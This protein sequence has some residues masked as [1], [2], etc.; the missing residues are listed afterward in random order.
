MFFLFVF[1]TGKMKLHRTHHY[2][3]QVVTQIECIKASYCDFVVWCPND[4]DIERIEPDQ[5][6]WAEIAEKCTKYFQEAII[7]EMLG[8]SHTIQHAKKAV[9]PY[10]YCQYHTEKKEKMIDCA[11]QS[12]P[13]NDFPNAL[14]RKN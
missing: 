10:D 14:Y 9:A 5:G 12:C 11:R 2:Y 4:F 7:P 1:Q 3:Y 6:T 13:K 8:R